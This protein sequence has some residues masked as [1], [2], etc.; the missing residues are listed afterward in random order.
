[1]R[2]HEIIDN[3]IDKTRISRED[4]QYII[5][6]LERH[7]IET[8]TPEEMQLMYGDIEADLRVEQQ[9]LDIARTRAEIEKLEAE[10]LKDRSDAFD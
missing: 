8:M 4:Y 5:N 6:A 7:G 10:A 9:R 1:M 3:Y 2:A